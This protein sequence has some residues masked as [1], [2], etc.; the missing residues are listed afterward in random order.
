MAYKLLTEFRKLFEGSKYKHRVSTHGDRVASFLY[1]DLFDLGR[2]AKY[3]AAVSSKSRVLNS[4]NLAVGKK[5][6]RG[7]GT[8]GE[9]VPHIVA[10]MA[11]NHTV[12]FAEVA[13]IELGTEVKILAKAMRKQLG[14]VCSDLE[15]QV[16][17]F[18]KHGGNPICVGIVGINWSE[19][20]TSFERRKVWKTTGKAGYPHPLQE[21]AGVERDLAS[22]VENMFDELVLLRFKATNERP[23]AFSWVDQAETE[24]LYASALIRISRDYEARF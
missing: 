9:R 24:K 6:R 23:Y 8:F 21:A 7:D 5:T 20:Y 17:E 22:R 1:E 15:K 3:V 12:A 11:P 13:T 14:R 16:K 2:S 18:K 19:S 10:V 4:K